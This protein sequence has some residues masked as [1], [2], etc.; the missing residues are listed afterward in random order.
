MV[1]AVST[2]DSPLR[3]LLWSTWHRSITA[4]RRFAA[5]SNDIS[6]RVLGS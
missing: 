4:P 1:R 3:T 5:R 6:V 2:S